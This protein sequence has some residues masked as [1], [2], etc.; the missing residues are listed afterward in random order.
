MV[1]VY[2][3]YHTCCTCSLIIPVPVP[4]TCPGIVC[5]H[6]KPFF[7][8]D[9]QHTNNWSSVRAESSYRNRSTSSVVTKLRRRQAATLYQVDSCS[10]MPMPQYTYASYPDTFHY[11]LPWRRIFILKE[12]KREDNVILRLQVYS[13]TGIIKMRISVVYLWHRYPLAVFVNCCEL[14][15]LLVPTR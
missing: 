5:T 10:T 15:L 13:S 4:G 2:K 6:I 1:H 14:P 9:I 3:Q 11:K 12:R 8:L 7:P